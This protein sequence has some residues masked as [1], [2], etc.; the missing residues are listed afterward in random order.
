MDPVPDL[1]GM[2]DGQTGSGDQFDGW[3]TAG[4]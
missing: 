2:I 4:T 3:G 1:E